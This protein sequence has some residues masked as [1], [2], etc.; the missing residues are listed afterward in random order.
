MKNPNSINELWSSEAIERLFDSSAIGFFFVG[1]DQKILDVNDAFCLK[2]GYTRDELVGMPIT[3]ITYPTDLESTAELF[4]HVNEENMVNSFEKRYVTRSGGIMW[5]KL[6]SEAVRD[7]DGDLEYR[8]VMAEDITEEKEN[9]VF[10]EQMAAI[11][12]ASGDAIFRCNKD[13][14]VEFW[15][16]GAEDLYGYTAQE[17]L[18]LN[19][20]FIVALPESRN[21][22]EAREKLARGEIVMD[23]ESLSRHKDGHFIEVSVQIF[24]IRD[25]QQNIV[26]FAAVH[27]DIS[28]VKQ[29][30]E[31]LRHSQRM[32]TAGLL[33]GGIAHDFNNIL[34]V[35]QGATEFLGSDIPQDSRSLRHLELIAK[36]TERASRLTRQLLAFSRKQQRVAQTFDPNALLEDFISVLKRTLGDDVILLTRFDSSWPIREDP[37]H[38]E[39]VILNLMLNARH[40]MPKGGKLR[41]TTQDV[42][43]SGE[44]MFFEPGKLRFAP[45]PIAPGEYVMLSVGDTGVGMDYQILEHIFDPFYTT[46]PKGEGT[47]LGL[48]VVYGIISQSGGSIRVIT[49][50]G[51]GSE[52]QVLF[53]RAEHDTDFVDTQPP[54]PGTTSKGRILVLEDNADVR[55]LSS[56]LLKSAG[57]TVIEAEN[58]RQVLNNEVDADVDLILSDVVMPGMSGPEFS[59]IWLKKH[60]EANFLFMSGFIDDKNMNDYLNPDNLIKKPFKPAELLFRVNQ[61]LTAR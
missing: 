32:E 35:I 33:A 8:I 53:P 27:R 11:V 21:I 44:D 34:T 61:K 41:V 2:T 39:Q 51:K 26:A 10:H 7:D 52:F 18:G 19:S 30:E 12:E 42:V 20:G 60:P 16:K 56:T 4:R 54:D 49:E 13:D 46:K 58:P 9:E 24:P 57:Y 15:S 40:A 23:P 50:V 29:L 47:G 48:S 43:I 38:L 25:K 36:S 22:R 28:K 59:V 5:F 6:R 14:I 37:T 3:D 31:Q 1:P 45:H 55:M 17:V